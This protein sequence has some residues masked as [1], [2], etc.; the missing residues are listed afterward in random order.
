M[1]VKG[2]TVRSTADCLIAQIAIENKLL[3]LHNDR[4]FEAMS[5]VAPLKF[6]STKSRQ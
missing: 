5:A 2:I 1:N 6:F 4:D 3:L